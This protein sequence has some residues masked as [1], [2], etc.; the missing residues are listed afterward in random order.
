MITS[1]GVVVSV[2]EAAA[3]L[4]VSPERVRDLVAAGHLK[5]TKYGRDLLVD[6]DSVL[7]RVHVVRPSAGRP[8]SPRMAWALL[9]VASGRRPGWIK[10]SELV[11]VRRYLDRRDLADWPRL[12][13]RRASMH[14]GRMLPATIKRLPTQ[15]GV[16]SG[17]VVAAADYGA[18]ILSSGDEG[19][20]YISP[21]VFARLREEGRISLEAERPNV[22]LRVPSLDQPDLLA[23][24][25]MPIAVVVADLLD[26]GEER[27]MRAGRRLL[28]QRGVGT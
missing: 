3:E 16:S 24:P 4:G 27:S 6:F 25:V 9:W 23:E 28:E 1:K 10:P 22:V 21:S 19:E 13:G 12:L 8:L 5:A 18:D 7:H 15:D 26:S 17:G 20:F 14:S 2:A 11:R